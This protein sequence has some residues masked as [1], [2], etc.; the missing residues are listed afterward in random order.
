[1]IVRIQVIDFFIILVVA[2]QKFMH[3]EKFIRSIDMIVRQKARRKAI[4]KAR[5]RCH[6]EHML[7]CAKNTSHKLYKKVTLY[8]VRVSYNGN[9]HDSAPCHDCHKTLTDMGIKRIVYSNDEGDLTSCKMTEYIPKSLTLG[10]RYI[11]SD[12]TLGLKREK[13][14]KERKQKQYKRYG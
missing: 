6:S 1:M 8:I 14:Q 12:F 13:Q 3:C 5:R 4:T 11:N 7:N 9:I 2:M 10:R